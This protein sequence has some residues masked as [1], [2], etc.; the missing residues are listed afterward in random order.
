MLNVDGLR[1][2]Y[3]TGQGLLKAV[4]GVSFSLQKG[5]IVGIVGESGCGKTTVA[6]SLV[7]LLPPV[8]RILGGKVMLHDNN[9]LTATEEQMRLVRWRK[10]SMI[11]QGALN[12]L[13]PVLPVKEQIAEAIEAHEHLSEK[14]L[15]ERID[16]LF[17]AV[18]LDVSRKNNFPHEFSGGMKQRV[19]IAMALACNPEIVIADEPTTALD[20]IVQY[21][22][23][24]LIRDL[25]RKLQLSMILITHDLSVVAEICDKVVIMY[26]GKVVECGEICQIFENPK[27]PYT[28]ALI[29]SIIKMES[30]KTELHFISGS[31][32]DLTGEVPACR[33]FGRCP[34]G[35][36]ICGEVEPPVE[37][38]EPNH[39]TSC[40]F[41]RETAK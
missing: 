41:W 3:K 28:R 35:Q 22:I 24:E 9:I 30:E 26:A 11:F 37:N 25:R 7:R 16:G 17:K 32:P 21:Q 2:H 38:V 19:M 13:N 18:G 36:R 39:V 4:D 27:H 6:L 12:S 8:A 29:W 33:F 23:L 14:E 31:M 15:D 34:H 1:V 5:E 40:H 10:I 20:L